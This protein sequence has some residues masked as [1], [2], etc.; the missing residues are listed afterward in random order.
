M[1]I[2]K[3]NT[4]TYRRR[5]CHFRKLCIEGLKIQLQHKWVKHAAITSQWDYKPVSQLL[6]R[7][8]LLNFQRAVR[9]IHLTLFVSKLAKAYTFNCHGLRTI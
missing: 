5:S 3:L 8:N 6:I 1:A 2:E 7:N 4:M 9:G